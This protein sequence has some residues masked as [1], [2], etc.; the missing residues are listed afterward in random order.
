[1]YIGARLRTLRGTSATA[2]GKS[3]KGPGNKRAMQNFGSPAGSVT[4][5]M[6]GSPRG[7]RRLPPTSY[8]FCGP[9]DQEA[10]AKAWIIGAKYPFIK[11]GV[12]RPWRVRLFFCANAVKAQNKAN[13]F[14][15]ALGLDVYS[16]NSKAHLR[17]GPE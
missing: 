1:M 14:F 4:S 3:A 6:R 11:D 12:E 2:F 5:S 16:G 17:T 7:V 10:A 15:T 13:K 9:A 8:A